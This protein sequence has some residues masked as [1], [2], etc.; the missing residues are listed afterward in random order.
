MNRKTYCSK[1]EVEELA[2]SVA[3]SYKDALVSKDSGHFIDGATD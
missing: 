1:A 3:I 2:L